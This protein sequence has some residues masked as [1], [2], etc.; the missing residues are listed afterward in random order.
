[1]PTKNIYGVEEPFTVPKGCG[2]SVSDP[3][4]ASLIETLGHEETMEGVAFTRDQIRSLRKL[5]GFEESSDG[6]MQAAGDWQDLG[7]RVQRDGLRAIAL[8][9]QYCELGDDPV[10]V[11]AGMARDCGYDIGCLSEWIDETDAE[12]K[13]IPKQEL[14]ER[15]SELKA[16]TRNRVKNAQSQVGDA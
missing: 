8:I 4:S 9:S 1:M 2:C 11:L 16:R 15:Y 5:Y 12:L 7:R 14:V 10:K 3:E 13:D 6:P